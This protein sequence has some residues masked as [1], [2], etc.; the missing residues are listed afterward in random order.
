MYYRV[1]RKDPASWN[2]VRVLEQGDGTGQG[3]R[4]RVR[5]RSMFIVLPTQQDETL[6]TIEEGE[7]DSA[8]R[9][10]KVESTQRVISSS[11]A[12]KSWQ[13]HCCTTELRLQHS[14]TSNRRK[15]QAG[16]ALQLHP[17]TRTAA[18]LQQKLPRTA[19]SIV[20]WN[21]SIV[22]IIAL[23]QIAQKSEAAISDWTEPLILAHTCLHLASF[24]LLASAAACQVV[25][26]NPTTLPL[27]SPPAPPLLL[28]LNKLRGAYL[29]CT[30]YSYGLS[31]CEI[32]VSQVR[33]LTQIDAMYCI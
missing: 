22:I 8:G 32:G 15:E 27:A 29:D 12:K 6:P 24:S 33:H 18:S 14:Q 9:G 3:D 20:P 25:P 11:R 16:R 30:L 17:L 28:L 19:T 7:G 23:A 21:P 31:S 5:A 10:F 1:C 26:A 13:I 4:V 2:G